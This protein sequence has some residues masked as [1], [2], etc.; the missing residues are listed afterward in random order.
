MSNLKNSRVH[1]GKAARILLTE[2]GLDIKTVMRR[3][4]LPPG[5]LDGDGSRISFDDFHRLWTSVTAE[6]EDPLLALKLGDAAGIDYFDPAFF[7]AMCSPD[8]NM[9]V[10]R[11]AEY[12]RLVSPFRFDVQIDAHSTQIAFHGPA[13]DAVHP[14]LA[15]TEIVF[16]VNFA[17]RATR[18]RVTPVSVTMPFDMPER[19]AYEA[20][21][22]CA[23]SQAEGRSVTFDAADARRPF[24]THNDEIWGLFEPQLQRQVA[25]TDRTLTTRTRVSHC[26]NEFLPS[27]RASVEEVARELAMSK[28]T[29]QRRL[30]EEGT[31]W[32]EVLNS[33]RETLA[34]HYLATT[35][36]GTAEVSFLL[37]FEDPNSFFRAFK[38]WEDTSPELWR[39]QNKVQHGRLH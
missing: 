25:G 26:L 3:A 23:I 36:Y 28:R 14:T 37:G 31:N 2:L 24:V 1:V 6:A 10:L 12:K 17:R 34:K 7:A 4:G 19:A 22:G 16:L 18:Q 29:L 39:V 35:E 32:L 13:N 5:L 9:A 8:M 27:G 11:L 20:H 21:L 38:R 30:A 15:L 33:A